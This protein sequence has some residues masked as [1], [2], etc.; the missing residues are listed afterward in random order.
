MFDRLRYTVRNPRVAIPAATVGSVVVLAGGSWLVFDS[1]L[2]ATLIALAV[3]LVALVVVLLRTIF[4]QEREDRLARGIEDRDQQ[5]QAQRAQLQQLARESL[6]E[7]SRR[8]LDEIRRSRLGPEGL[9]ELPW[10]LVIGEV[11]AGKSEVLRQSGLDLPAEYAHLLRGGTTQNCDWWL[12]NQAIVLDTAG[13][14]L[15]ASDDAGRQWRRLLGLLRRS[16]PKLPLNGLVVAVPVPTLLSQS[17]EEL[18]QKAHTLRRRINEL[19]DTL[20]LDVPIYVLVTKADQIEGFSEAVNALAREH[21]REAFG[22][23]N[24][25]RSFADAGEEALRGFEP[26]RQRLERLMPEMTMREADPRRRRRL[27]TFA[28][29]FGETVRAAADFLRI[30]FAPS[31]YD[32]VPFLRGVYFTS[33]KREGTPLSPVLRRFGQEWAR[34]TVTA[35]AAPVGGL[36]LSDVFREVVLGDRDL[37]LPAYWLGRRTR[38]VLVAAVAAVSLTAL[39]F[40]GIGFVDNLGAVR[41]LAA[42]AEAVGAGASSLA[43]IERLRQAI[44]DREAQPFPLGAL[45]LNSP[46]HRAL[47]RAR[48]TFNWA[49]GREFEEPTKGRLIGIVGSYG[50]ADFEAL[51]ELGLDISFL[52]TRGESL[53]PDLLAY[54][55]VGRSE[56]D[57]EAFAAGYAAFVRWIP[58]G[59]VSSRIDQE[60]KVQIATAGRLLTIH[61][62][63]DWSD[64]SAAKHPPI[65][66]ESLAIPT[67]PD[68]PSTHV[69]GAYT[70]ATWE[71]LVRDL[72]ESVERSGAAGGDQVSRF[73]EEYVK[74]YDIKWRD[75]LMDTPLA[76]HA[77]PNLSDS[78]YI[79]LLRTIDQNAQ[80]ELP[81]RGAPPPYIGAVHEALRDTPADEEVERPPPW[82]AYESALEQLEADVVAAVE[83]PDQALAQAAKLSQPDTSRFHGAIAGVRAMVPVRGDPKAGAKVQEILSMPLLNGASALLDRALDELERRWVQRIEDPFKGQLDSQS[84]RALYQ[85]VDGALARFEEDALGVFY[86]DGHPVALIGDRAMPFGE[87][88]MA[89][90]RAAEI[91][92]STIYPRPG[93]APITVRLEGIP[94][95]MA[96]PSGYFITRRELRM[97]CAAGDQTF[98]Y[99]EGPE[100]RSFTWTPDCQKVTLRVFARTADGPERELGPPLEKRGPLALPQLLQSAQRLPGDRLQW[101]VRYDDPRLEVDFEYWLR[102]GQD[103][104]NIA[105]RP[106]PRSMRE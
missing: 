73:R 96:Q 23:T 75:F 10:L 24:N 49:F 30:V 12:T 16:R 15:E 92:R 59:E 31:V 65:T 43:S 7:R 36:F 55:P 22:W 51:A 46:T 106:P 26:V 85:P 86:E 68:G 9:Y 18:D 52:G 28:D 63:E 99:R 21:T 41:W 81:R 84:L 11:G 2:L 70:R 14:L 67:G 72:V 39:L 6:E 45:G 38:R 44:A 27:F 35:D 54:A 87:G 94:S 79:R 89:W 40:L 37:A 82:T 98:V 17:G 74:R 97:A 32:E 29:D 61:A 62:L 88:F 80:A 60:R 104:L 53:A 48:R 4:R 64:R 47:G 34:A 105:H 100:S 25:R 76:L 91:M 20:R 69:T 3:V 57:T 90:M 19:T 93:A 101:S 66:Y 56:A 95:H 5:A 42:E 8:A 71:A 102:V 77:D 78:P 58:D 50:D 13:A 1:W 83:Q 33:A 103:I